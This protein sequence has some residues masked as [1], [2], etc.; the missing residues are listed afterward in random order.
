MK[1][2]EGLDIELDYFKKH[3]VYSTMDPKYFGIKSLTNN[4]KIRVKNVKRS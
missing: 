1:V 2:K 4:L 3:P